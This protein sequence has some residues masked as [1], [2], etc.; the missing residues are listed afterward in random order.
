MKQNVQTKSSEEPRSEDR[1]KNHPGDAIGGIRMIKGGPTTR[2]SFR[3]LK[4]AQQ[5]QVN[6]VH[7]M[8]QSK[9]QQRESS[10]MAFFEEDARGIK[11]PHDDP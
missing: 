4:K 11:Q 6:S 7:A 5:R 9:H 8:R 2:A 3:S 1:L 10:C